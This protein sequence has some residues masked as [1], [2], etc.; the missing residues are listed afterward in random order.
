[1]QIY[2]RLTQIKAISFD[3]DDTLYNNRPVMQVIETKMNAYFTEKFAILLPTLILKS[4]QTFNSN[5]WAPYRAQV[6]QAQPVITHDVVK[7]R[8]ETYR[9]GFLAH[10]LSEEVAVQEAQAGLDY[11]IE[12]RSDFSVPQVTHDLLESLGR[13]FP[14]VSI[15]N[16]NVNTKTLGIDHYFQHIYHAGYQDYRANKECEYLLKQKPA[17]DMFD[18]VCKQ[19]A[20]QPSELLH[21]GD[22]GLAD[23]Y[24]ALNAGCQTA[25]LPQYGIGKQLKQI[26]H[27]ELGRV[28]ELKALLS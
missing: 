13:V 16:G 21:V 9:L 24:G 18:L 7:I 2:R 4:D 1:M 27:I 19:L 11:F 10:N 3:L 25:Y 5:F 20:I 22:C 14:I 12:L 23:I 15:S 6:V 8:F 28:E 26:P 17:T